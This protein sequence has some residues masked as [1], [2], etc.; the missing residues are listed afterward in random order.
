MHTP[1]VRIS[2]LSAI[3]TLSSAVFLLGCATVAPTP[4]VPL[5]T[6][7]TLPAG[8]IEIPTATTAPGLDSC[9]VGGYP[10]PIVLSGSPTERPAVWSDYGGERGTIVWPIGYYATFNPALE[11]WDGL[12]HVVARQGDNL[13]TLRIEGAV[14][15]VGPHGGL[16]FALP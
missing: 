5:A 14:V 7:A 15:C 16:V 3:S 1:L 8:A 13:S 10:T 4:T 11:V 6:L 9:L 2:L 12:G